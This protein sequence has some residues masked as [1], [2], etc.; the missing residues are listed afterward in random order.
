MNWIEESVHFEIVRRLRAGQS[1]RQIARDLEVAKDTVQVRKQMLVA[2][3]ASLPE[4]R[5]GRTRGEPVFRK[6]KRA[7]MV[8]RR[9]RWFSA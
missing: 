5:G 1:I 3:G 6:A 7:A 2:A 4:C 9:Y 8:S